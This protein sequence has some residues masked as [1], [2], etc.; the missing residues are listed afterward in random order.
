MP[1]IRDV[2]VDGEACAGSALCVRLAPE[3]FTLDAPFCTGGPGDIARHSVRI[4]HDSSRTQWLRSKRSRFITLFQAAT[5][6]VT[7]AACESA[8]A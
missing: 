2:I 3:V 7:K 6:S 8:D 5:K 1:G 4:D